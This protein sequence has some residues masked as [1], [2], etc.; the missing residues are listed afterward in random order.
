[1]QTF[2]TLICSC[3]GAECPLHYSTSDEI[4]FPPRVDLSPVLRFAPSCSFLLLLAWTISRLR[5][6]SPL[7]TLRP[8]TIPTPFLSTGAFFN[9]LLLS[10]EGFG[11]DRIHEGT[12]HPDAWTMFAMLPGGKGQNQNAN[13][14]GTD[15]RKRSRFEIWGI[16]ISEIC[17]GIAL[18]PC[19]TS[20]A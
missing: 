3:Q 12:G 5:T 17:D 11:R 15:R 19:S 14:L 4:L 10:L 1:M 18:P 8:A 6:A 2:P 20:S 16:D 9:C 13:R 7:P